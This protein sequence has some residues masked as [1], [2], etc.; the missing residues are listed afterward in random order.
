MSAVK[1][2]KEY[3]IL[4]H[5]LFY[6]FRH[7]RDLSPEQFLQFV[8]SVLHH[9]KAA[10][11]T[12]LRR[13]SISPCLQ[14]PFERFPVHLPV[15]E[16]PD[17]PSEFHRMQKVLRSHGKCLPVILFHISHVVLRDC[18]RA[19]RTDRNAVPAQD[20]VRFPDRFLFLNSDLSGRAVLRAQSAANAFLS[21]YRNHFFFSFLPYRFFIFIPFR[22][23]PAEHMPSPGFPPAS[24]P[25]IPTGLLSG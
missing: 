19:L 13:R 17:T 12:V 8:Q 21:V 16:I 22:I 6:P 24:I 9:D 25:R 2:L 3:R 11:L 1:E 10:R 20:T 5:G 15:L 4:G 7:I 18:H 23:Y 14:D